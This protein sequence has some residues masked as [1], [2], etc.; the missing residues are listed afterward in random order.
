MARSKYVR[1]KRFMHA[2]PI[3]VKFTVHM[4]M[5]PDE[6][7]AVNVTWV[8][9]TG[10]SSRLCDTLILKRKELEQFQTSI[11]NTVLRKLNNNRLFFIKSERKN[12]FLYD[13]CPN[14]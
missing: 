10:M 4:F 7:V 9:P 12:H 8:M 5:F 13:C 2:L 1:T 6:S 3:T 11:L 14:L